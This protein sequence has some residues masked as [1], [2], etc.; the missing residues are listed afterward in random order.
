MYSRIEEERPDYIRRSQHAANCTADNSSAS[1]NFELHTSFL[2]S[3]KWASEQTADSLALARTYG[4]PSLFITM[5]C[6]RSKQD[7]VMARDRVMCLLS[8]LAHLSFD[9]SDS[10]LLR[11]KFGSLIY[12]IKVIEFQK[13]GLPHTH[14]I[15][16]I[17]FPSA[18]CTSSHSVIMV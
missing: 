11:T 9:F 17:C 18:T 5:T 2:G 14:I 12:I 7:F 8:S 15:I 13:R 6:L 16:K 4:P 3:R 10:C 1:H